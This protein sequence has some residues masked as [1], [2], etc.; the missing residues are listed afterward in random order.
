MAELHPNA[1]QRFNFSGKVAWVIG[2]AGLLGSEVCRGLAEHGAHVVVSDVK[3]DNSHQVADR[4]QSAGLSAEV[5]VLDASDEAAVG[6][7]VDDIV[8]RHGRL[9]AMVYMA[10][11]YVP[12]PMLELPAED[13]EQCMRVTLTGAF[14]AGRESARVMIKQG[15]GSIVQFSSMYGV[16]SPDPR[17]YPPPQPVN[18]IHYGVAKAGVL[19]MVRYQAVMLAPQGVRVNA[20]VPG[21]FPYPWS[22]GADRTFVERLSAKVPMG[23]VGKA[24]EIVGAVVFLCSDAASYVTG[25][26]IVVD[27]GWTA[28]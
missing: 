19:Q 16:V 15:F 8:A 11:Y 6:R 24:P 7:S 13:W 3:D 26:S 10:Y 14:I 2:G 23:R 17:M 9:D 28:W 22:Q 20:V 25:T 27:G 12:K 5:T 1:Q 18:P 4:L 21:P